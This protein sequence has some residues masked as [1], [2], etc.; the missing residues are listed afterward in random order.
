MEVGDDYSHVLGWDKDEFSVTHR[1]P[2]FPVRCFGCK[3]FEHEKG[4]YVYERTKDRESVLCNAGK[5]EKGA[6]R[7]VEEIARGIIV[8]CSL[9]NVKHYRDRSGGVYGQMVKIQGRE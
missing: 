5:I 2:S 4:F 3:K 1:H 9:S 6:R 7:K 8:E